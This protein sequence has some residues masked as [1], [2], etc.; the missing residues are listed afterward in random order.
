[1]PV[2][3]GGNVNGIDVVAGQQF[4]EVVVGGTV[5]VAV[6]GV[7]PIL[8]RLQVVLSHIAYRDILHVAAGQKGVLIAGALVA[9]ADPPEHHSVAGWGSRG[10]AQR[11]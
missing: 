9:D 4:A 10:I 8:R 6:A 3:G 1:M 2:V 5:A 7:D 11:R